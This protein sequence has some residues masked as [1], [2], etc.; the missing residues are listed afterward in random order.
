M[1]SSCRQ[2]LKPKNETDNEEEIDE[3]DNESIM[4]CNRKNQLEERAAT[5][6][7]AN[8]SS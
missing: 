3:D 8:V 6:E 4:E 7:D 2:V 5:D 1:R